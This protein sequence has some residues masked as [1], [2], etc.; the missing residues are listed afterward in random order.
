MVLEF[1]DSGG[2][3]KRGRAVSKGVGALMQWTE[4]PRIPVCGE[5]QISPE[6]PRLRTGTI[7]HAPSDYPVLGEF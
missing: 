4:A 3:L 1:D 6:F 7:V 5:F 2:R